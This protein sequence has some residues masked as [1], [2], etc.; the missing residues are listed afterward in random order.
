MMEQSERILVLARE[1]ALPLYVAAGTYLN[2]LAKWC[3]GNRQAGL[4]EMRQGWVLLHE[5]DCYLY[6]PF[7]GLHVAE[8]E[9]GMGQIER[10]LTTL[11]ELIVWSKQT[12]QHWLDAELFRVRGELLRC[13]D[14]SDVVAAEDAFKQAVDVAR[15]QQTKTFELRAAL[16]LAR[17]YVAQDRASAVIEI[18]API[19]SAFD[20]EGSLPEIKEGQTLLMSLGE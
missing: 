19:L 5:N 15:S 3:T 10:G 14:P 9:A 11:S 8:A 4:A 18:L 13:I 16:G 6:E 7:W 17:L 1:H 20:K 2:G 12:G